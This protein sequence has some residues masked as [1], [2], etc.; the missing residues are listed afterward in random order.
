MSEILKNKIESLWDGRSQ[1]TSCIAEAMEK[2]DKGEL[3]IAEKKDGVWHVNDYLKKAIL[4]FFKHSASE[5]MH[6]EAC[7]FFD[8]VPLKTA[9][10]TEQDFIRAGFRA[11]PNSYVRYSA[12]VAKSVVLMPSFVNVGA[13]I[14]EGT[15]IDSN[16][17]VGSCAQIGKNCHISDGVTIG[18]V[19]EPLQANPV[20]VEDNCFIGVRSAVTEGVIIQEGAVLSSG[21]LLTASTK[22]IDRESGEIS[23]GKIPP[24]SVVVSGTYPSGNVNLYCAVIVKRVT[25]QTRKK[26][27]V[28]ELL[29]L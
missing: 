23:Y 27:S 10:W 3:R 9:G 6:G 21:V 29:R 4:L 16:V 17:L 22:I 11:V 12:Y 7:N 8:K 24:Y 2:L 14:D 18:G 25:E 19:L 20:I 28:N 1:N 15:M 26:T 5:V 13:Y